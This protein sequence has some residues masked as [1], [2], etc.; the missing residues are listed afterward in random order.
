MDGKAEVQAGQRTGV[1]TE[2]AERMR[3]LEREVREPRQANGISREASTWFAQAELD[4][5][6]RK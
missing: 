4:H 2:V 6:L 3:A 1:P 5:P